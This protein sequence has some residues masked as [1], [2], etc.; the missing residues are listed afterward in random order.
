MKSTWEKRKNRNIKKDQTDIGRSGKV[1][2]IGNYTLSQDYFVKQ[3]TFSKTKEK[4]RN[5]SKETRN[6]CVL[7]GME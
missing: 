5:P 6:E 3:K 7:L 1:N 2:A 4:R